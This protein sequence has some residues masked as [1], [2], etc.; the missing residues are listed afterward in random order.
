MDILK[1]PFI[2]K[3][4]IQYNDSGTLKLEFCQSIQNHVGTIHASAQFVLAEAASGD[5]LQALFPELLDK[6]FV[7]LRE[8]KIKYRK[9]AEQSISAYSSVNKNSILVFRDQLTKKG[10]GTIE[11]TVE[12][13]DM[14]GNITCSGRFKWFVQTE[15]VMKTLPNNV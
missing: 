15:F 9:P 7:V 4:G 6:V 8:A 11:I 12:I 10:K 3:T 2:Q 5:C 1:I 14:D 13:K